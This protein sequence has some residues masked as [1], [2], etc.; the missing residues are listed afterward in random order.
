VTVAISLRRTGLPTV[1]QAA[2][3]AVQFFIENGLYGVADIR[4]QPV[5]D[6]VEAIVASE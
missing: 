6:R 3:K 1:A 5:F 4:A 2:E